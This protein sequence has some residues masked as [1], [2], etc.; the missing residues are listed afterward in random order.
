MARRHAAAAFS[1]LDALPQRRD[2]AERVRGAPGASGPRSIHG[3]RRVR[4][5]RIARH[6]PGPDDAERSV[7]REHVEVRLWIA[8]LKQDWKSTRLNCSHK[9]V[10]YDVFS[11]KNK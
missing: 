2:R 7:A 10:W 4:V 8:A 5:L 6:R 9:V 3:P 1:R 11:L